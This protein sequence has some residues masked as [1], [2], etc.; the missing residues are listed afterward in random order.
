MR[1]FMCMYV[2]VFI[3]TLSSHAG[4]RRA[5]SMSPFHFPSSSVFC[6]VFCGS[7]GLTMLENRCNRL[8]QIAF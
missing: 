4:H 1:T 8:H 6:A 5:V 7:S 3:P 2:Y